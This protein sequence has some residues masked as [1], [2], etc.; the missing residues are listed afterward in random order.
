MLVY[1]ITGYA[2]PK[3]ADG[4]YCILRLMIDEKHQNRGYGRAALHEIRNYIRT[5]PA[6]YCWISYA[7]ENAVAKGLHKS[8]GIVET[9]EQNFGERI[10]T[11]AQIKL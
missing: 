3:I 11:I 9:G 2:V 10:E 5:Y 1:G 7:P 4:N 6:R 8:V